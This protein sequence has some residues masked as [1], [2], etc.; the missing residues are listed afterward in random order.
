MAQTPDTKLQ[1]I[2]IPLT[3]KLITS[4]DGTELGEG[5]FQVLKNMR[6]GDRSPSSVSGHTKINTS[7]INSTYLKPRSGFHFRKFQPAESYVFVQSWNTGLTASK[8]YQSTTAIPNQGNFTEFL[9]ESASTADIGKFSDAPDGCMIY[10]NGKSSYI[11]GGVEYRCGGL[12]IGNLDGTVQFDYSRH[13]NNTLT[14]SNNVAIFKTVAVTADAN[15]MILLHLNN[16]VTDSCPD[17]VPGTHTVTNANVT[18][19]NTLYKW[20]YSA[21]FNGTT[22]YLSTP[23]NADFDFSTATGTDG[24]WTIDFWVIAD[25]MAGITEGVYFQ[26]TDDTNYMAITLEAITGTHTEGNNQSVLTDSTKSWTI[27]EFKYGGIIIN[28][29]DG[30]YGTITSNTANTITATLTGGTDND[31]DTND[32]YE[33]SWNYAVKLS[34]YA[35][36]E[37]VSLMTGYVLPN[38]T[39]HHIEVSENG[40]DYYIF[41]DGVLKASSTDTDRPGA[42]SG[43]IYIGCTVIS[44]TTKANYLMADIDEFRISNICRHTAGFAPQIVPYGSS[45]A[46]YAFVGSTRPISGAKFYV[47]TANTAVGAARAYYWENGGWIEVGSL[48]DGTKT[49]TTPNFVTLG[50]NGTISFNTTVSVAKPKIINNIYLYWYMFV[51]EAIDDT[52]SVSYITLS[53]PLQS[54]VDLWDGQYRPIAS[55]YKKKA[56]FNDETVNVLKVDWQQGYTEAYSNINALTTAYYLL[57]GFSERT[58]GIKFIFTKDTVTNSTA[59]VMTVSY[60]NGTAWTSVGAISDG[61]SESGKSMTRTGVVTWDTPN[62]GSESKYSLNTNNEGFW[63]YKISFDHTLV[64]STTV[65]GIDCI[66][67]I[68]AQK[69]IHGYGICVAWQDRVWLLNDSYDKKNSAI[70][71]VGGTVCVF[72]GTDSVTPDAPMEFGDE[73][74]IVAAA[75]LYTRFGGSIYD[76]LISFKKHE[77]WLVDG[78]T[79]TAPENNPSVGYRKY[80]IADY[81]CLDPETLV[82][83]NVGYEIAPGLLKHVLIWRSDSA[84]LLFDGNAVIPISGDISNY[85]DPTKPEYISTSTKTQGFYD[86]RRFEYH[87]ITPL[88]EFVYDLIKKKWFQID[89]ASGA[90]LSM[91]FS[92]YSTNGT[93]YVYGGIDT[94]YIMLLENGTT[95]GKS[96]GGNNIVSTY[97]IPDISLGNW[98]NITKIRRIKHIAVSKSN[99]VNSAVISHYGDCSNTAT[100]QIFSHPIKDINKRI[101]QRIESVN[102]GDYL[103][104][105]IQCSLIT[106]DELTAFEPIGLAIKYQVIREDLI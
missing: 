67:G 81:G 21:N 76:N 4:R 26:K 30:S 46:C 28:I 23:D 19:S 38:D 100:S 11:W 92:V 52:T 88:L 89:R 101:T 71:S 49:G 37:V 62:E 42:Y 47:Q 93:S 69:L 77:M 102:W 86:E 18:F 97:R 74:G 27:N 43:V 56:V 65:V 41:I 91:G 16:N 104:H 99:T 72:N 14:D 32:V 59:A 8:V 39:W 96:S 13:I 73:E 5:D 98:Q 70:C 82:S 80:K 33:I 64:N 66:Q 3:G 61:T 90:Y 10:T 51:F 17:P 1:T 83:C 103:F 57:C 87:W 35:T 45:N 36:T 54:I 75:T 78:I 85:F 15:T 6:Y 24:K 68:P 9:D 29:T 79:P 106:S 55:Y 31:W 63:Y 53:A 7:I 34:I 94:G 84:I 12:V 50:Q 48:V 40:D 2:N 105:S 44:G 60:W 25:K 20:G 95:F 22:A 58:T